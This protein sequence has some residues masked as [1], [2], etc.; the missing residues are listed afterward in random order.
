MSDVVLCVLLQ[1]GVV[2]SEGFMIGFEVELWH[3]DI[4]ADLRNRFRSEHL[5]EQGN[6]CYN[7]GSNSSTHGQNS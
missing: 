3:G 4:V 5:G 7:C 6:E 2:V 1:R